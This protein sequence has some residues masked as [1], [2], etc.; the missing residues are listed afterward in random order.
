MSAPQERNREVPLYLF[1]VAQALLTALQPH[2]NG[3]WDDS[4]CKP[5]DLVTVCG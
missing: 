1:D 3:F 4:L 2:D 5:H